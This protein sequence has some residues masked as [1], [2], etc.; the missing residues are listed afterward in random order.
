MHGAQT[1]PITLQRIGGA[2]VGRT[3]LQAEKREILKL[4]ANHNPSM[5]ERS[6]RLR[7]NLPCPQNPLVVPSRGTEEDPSEQEIRAPKESV[8][9]DRLPGSGHRNVDEATKGERTLE[10]EVAAVEE[11]QQ[12]PA[13][14]SGEQHPAGD[15]APPRPNECEGEDTREDL[16]DAGGPHQYDESRIATHLG[17]P[18]AQGGHPRCA[19]SGPVE[20]RC[21]EHERPDAR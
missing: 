5:A 8:P 13:P 3:C 21:G 2:R 14:A 11:Q 12:P 6:Q 10:D 17:D 1:S 7:R 19:P 16:R 18:G 20:A 9:A 15:P 4:A